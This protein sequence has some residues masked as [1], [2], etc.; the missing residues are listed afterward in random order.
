[1]RGE[2]GG[3]GQTHTKR[4]GRGQGSGQTS[5]K[6]RGEGGRMGKGEEPYN[7]I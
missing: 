7:L 5:Y 6:K 2:G 4:G 1:M 3:L